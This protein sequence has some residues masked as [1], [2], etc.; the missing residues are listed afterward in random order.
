MLP[1][2][3]TTSPPAPATPG[4]EGACRGACK[5]SSR[6][7]ASTDL[8]GL[9][10]PVSSWEGGSQ[11]E[12]LQSKSVSAWHANQE[13]LWNAGRHEAGVWDREKQPGCTPK[14]PEYRLMD[15]FGTELRSWEKPRDD[16]VHPPEEGVGG[17]GRRHLARGSAWVGG[18]GL[19][20]LTP[21]PVAAPQTFPR[22]LSNLSPSNVKEAVEK[23]QD[24]ASVRPDKGS[25]QP[26]TPD[27]RG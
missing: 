1:V 22:S 26:V 2:P 20:V 14:P 7:W 3:V 27:N 8:Q 19:S 6:R 12:P 23:S 9:R 17:Q 24:S 15:R 25:R 5:A 13:R 18:G 11:T 4:G 10:G 16:G 21:S